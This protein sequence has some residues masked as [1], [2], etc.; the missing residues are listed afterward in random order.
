[1][2]GGVKFGEEEGGM[3]ESWG[4]NSSQKYL[5]KQWK[6][7]PHASWPQSHGLSNLCVEF[8]RSIEVEHCKD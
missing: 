7:H 5:G 8:N 1:M 4:I 3:R 2:G 6:K